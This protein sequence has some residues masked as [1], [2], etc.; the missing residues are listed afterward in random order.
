M[1]Q[2]MGNILEEYRRQLA[3][4][5]SLAGR[6]D[7]YSRVILDRDKEI[8]MLQSML[9]E[10]NSYRSNLD[11]QVNELQELQEGIAAL[12]H[13]VESTSFIGTN[14][15]TPISVPVSVDEQLEQLKLKYTYLQSQLSDLQQQLTELN[16]R[17]LL[18]QQQTSR[19]AEL[20]SLL[21]Y[22]ETELANLKSLGA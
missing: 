8:E 20:E 17:N 18:L 21:E 3:L 16:T 10:A 9:A 22:A 4:N 14:R 12:Q 19:I 6:L 11:S 7:E 2:G 15:I 5:A 13:Q 1:E